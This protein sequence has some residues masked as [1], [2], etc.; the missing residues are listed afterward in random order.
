MKVSFSEPISKFNNAASKRGA[1]LLQRSGVAKKYAASELVGKTVNLLQH[2]NKYM[3]FGIITITVKDFIGMLAYFYQSINNKEIPVEK[4][5]YVASYELMNGLINCV[6]P[7]ALGVTIQ[8]EKVLDE[9]NYRLFKKLYVDP[10]ELAK[11]TGTAK[12]ALQ[13]QAELYK[14]C[15]GGLKTF[16][17]IVLAAIISKR[18]IAPF[19]A[20]PAAAWYKKKYMNKVDANGPEVHVMHAP[21]SNNSKPSAKGAGIQA[22]QVIPAPNL[23][24]SWN[25]KTAEQKVYG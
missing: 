14:T 20:G 8:N 24:A 5:K 16:S 11:A 15:R 9:V 18:I 6:L 10:Q 1:D 19:I 12:E 7:F 23:Q 22:K 17:A 4:R 21:N 25:P 2:Q 13:K 3:W